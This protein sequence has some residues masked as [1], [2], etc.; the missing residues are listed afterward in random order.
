MAKFMLRHQYFSF[1]LI[2]RHGETITSPHRVPWYRSDCDLRPHLAVLSSGG[3]NVHSLA[4]FSLQ[5][6]AVALTFIAVLG[7]GVA[8]ST[9]AIVND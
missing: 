1:V 9:R 5:V 8:Q 6:Q 2:S 7:A 4:D 3:R